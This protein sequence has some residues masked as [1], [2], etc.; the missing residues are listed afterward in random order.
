MSANKFTCAHVGLDF[1]GL[2]FCKVFQ[3]SN[4]DLFSDFNISSVHFRCIN[5]I[6]RNSY[7]QNLKFKC[8][9]ANNYM[10]SFHSCHIV[11]LVYSNK[12][13]QENAFLNSVVIY[14]NYLT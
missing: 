10:F 6:L 2:R 9:A 1:T 12:V 8:V 13:Q 4:Q 3:E 5:Y 14:R 7:K 11:I